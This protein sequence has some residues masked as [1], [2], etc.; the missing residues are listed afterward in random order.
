MLEEWDVEGIKDG[1]PVQKP[2]AVIPLKPL[3]QL[4]TPSDGAF[5]FESPRAIAAL[6]PPRCAL[7]VADDIDRAVHFFAL[8]GRYKRSLYER[9]RG[10]PFASVVS[11]SLDNEPKMALSYLGSEVVRIADWQGHIVSE[12]TMPALSDSQMPGS[13]LLITDRGE[14]LEHWGGTSL[15]TWSHSWGRRGLPLIRSFSSNGELISRIGQVE[16]SP[17]KVLPAALS[18][19]FIAVLKDTVWFARSADA[20]LFAAP[21]KHPGESPAELQLMLSPP[22]FFGMRTPYEIDIGDGSTP[23]GVGLEYHLRGLAIAGDGRY[24]VWVQIKSWPDPTKPNG[25]QRP[26]TLLVIYDRTSGRYSIA[27]PGLEVLD[28]QVVDDVGYL[29]QIDPVAERRLVRAFKLPLRVNSP[30]TPCR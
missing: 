30:R 10:S 21:L 18:R 26:G 15:A 29:L 14:V 20:R 7:V 16:E 9:R 6:G 5:L 22:L 28:L 4:Q 13:R 3:F 12:W 1:R 25:P 11:V 24:F 2:A 17:G 19:G 27:D 8:N 23:H